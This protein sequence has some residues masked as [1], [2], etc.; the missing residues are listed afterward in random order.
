MILVYQVGKISPNRI[1]AVY[2]QKC[3]W[4]RRCGQMESPQTAMITDLIEELNKIQKEII[5]IVLGGDLMI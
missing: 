2:S 5:L 1:S 4:L 3:V